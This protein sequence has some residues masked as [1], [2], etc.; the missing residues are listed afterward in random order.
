MGGGLAITTETEKGI[1]AA[2]KKH[3]LFFCMFA[4]LLI[5]GLIVNHASMNKEPNS[6]R[7][8]HLTG[9]G[10]PQ[11][12]V[13]LKRPDLYESDEERKAASEKLEKWRAEMKEFIDKQ[14]ELHR[15]PPTSAEIENQRYVDAL[16]AATDPEKG[17]VHDR[18][19]PWALRRFLADLEREQ[20][21]VT[22]TKRFIDIVGKRRERDYGAISEQA[23]EMCRHWLVWSETEN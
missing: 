13:G 8:I 6:H 20:K 19:P 10:M 17:L 5:C 11:P 14:R 22:P 4:G 23:G 12:P 21:P 15:K 18:L 3:R 7:V 9:P 2:M 1:I 16:K